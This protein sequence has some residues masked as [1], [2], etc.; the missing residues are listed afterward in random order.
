VIVE[1]IREHAGHR[2][3]GGLRWGVEAICRVLTEH[4]LPIAPS[5]YYERVNRQPCARE[6]SETLPLNEIRRVRRENY[7]VYGARKMCLEL[8]RESHPVARC[9]VERLMLAA[10]LGGVIRGKVKR[11]TIPDRLLREPGTWSAGDAAPAAPNTLVV[12]DMHPRTHVVRVGARGRSSL[13]QVQ[14]ILR[15]SAASRP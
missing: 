15:P 7:A 13:T 8:N 2:V 9:A 11:T 12:A 6:R 1:F 10:G 3:D 4:G 14:L 5:M